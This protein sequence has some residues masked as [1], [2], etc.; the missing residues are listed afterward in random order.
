MEA[1]ESSENPKGDTNG[2]RY[3]V[4]AQVRDTLLLTLYLPS[5]PSWDNWGNS[6]ISPLRYHIFVGLCSFEF[7]D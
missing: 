2:P 4:A 7:E 1:F 6:D 5:V 3:R